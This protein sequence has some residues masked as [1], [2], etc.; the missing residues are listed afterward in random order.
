MHICTRTYV[1]ISMYVCKHIHTKTKTHT[2]ICKYIWFSAHSHY[3]VLTSAISRTHELFGEPSGGKA[4]TYVYTYV[5]TN[6]D[7][8]NTYV[9]V[10][11]ENTNCVI[12]QNRMLRS[13]VFRS[14]TIKTIKEATVRAHERSVIGGLCTWLDGCSCMYIHTYVRKII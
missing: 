4:N 12:F 11:T 2:Y 1:H 9:Y 13:T 14:E 7:I 8:Q 10:H 6:M 5:H 3:F